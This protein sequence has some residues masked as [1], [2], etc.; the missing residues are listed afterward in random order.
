[1]ALIRL[2]DVSFTYRK[3]ALLEDIDLEVRPG[4][5][6]GLLGRNGMGKSTLM[7]II[8]GDISPDSRGRH[9]RCER[10]GIT[11]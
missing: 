7:K 1:M 2:Q 9:P 4:E 10:A 6:I 5:R 3:P 11:A 8:A